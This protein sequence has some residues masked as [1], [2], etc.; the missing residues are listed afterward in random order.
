MGRAP[1]ALRAGEF[2]LRQIC[3]QLP[4]Q[5]AKDCFTEWSAELPAIWDDEALPRWRAATRVLAYC[6]GQ[7]HTAQSLT[8]PPGEDPAE[9]L[10]ATPLM[11]AALISA[12]STD[13]QGLVG[14]ISTYAIGLLSLM[15]V[16]ALRPRRAKRNDG[17][18][19]SG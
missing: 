6:H 13:A 12:L 11:G 9:M 8:P 18:G 14:D 19:S 7:R 15:G 4:A 16:I 10:R 5:E 2:I 17:S 1:W 3:H